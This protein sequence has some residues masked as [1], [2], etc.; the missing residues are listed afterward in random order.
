M[1]EGPSGTRPARRLVV[2]LGGRSRDEAAL[3][4]AARIARRMDAELAAL[5]LQ[6]TELLEMAALPVSALLSAHTCERRR[7]DIVA[8]ERGYRVEARRLRRLVATVSERH[9]VRWSFEIMR[10]RGGELARRLTRD[11]LL[12]ITPQGRAERH[13]RLADVLASP[14]ESAILIMEPVRRPEYRHVAALYEGADAVPAAA[15]RLAAALEA[16]L[17]VIPV[18][19]GRA[20]PPTDE[21]RLR[22]WREGIGAAF[23]IS[24]P[25]A[26]E[27]RPLHETLERL[28]PDVVAIGRNGPVLPG[29][30]L[31][32][33][34]SL[35]GPRA[36]LVAGEGA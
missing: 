18:N 11:E 4:V 25:V 9:F 7:L 36:V 5:L 24:A 16:A 3:S 17:T 8:V 28:D 23:S 35:L 22:R 31:D 30:G 19:G 6:D 13:R 26:G 33:L 27:E 15:A 32:T 21:T 34:E 1:S 2:A 14:A 10:A 20:A 29:L 12:V